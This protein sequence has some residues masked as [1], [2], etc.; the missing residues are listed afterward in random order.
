MNKE[1]ITRLEKKANA[2]RRHILDMSYRAKSAHSGGAYSVVEILVTLYF[3]VM[4]VNP[5][6]DEDPKRDRL[7]FSK[8]HDAKALYAVLAE[9]GFFDKT[10][11]EK[12][13]SDD[14]IL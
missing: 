2:V 12:Y 1:T 4:H 14:G 10:I 13:E 8:A 5:K 11:L 7:I 3:E 9:R 6:N